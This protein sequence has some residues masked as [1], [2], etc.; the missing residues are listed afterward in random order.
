MEECSNQ[1]TGKL[2]RIIKRSLKESRV[3]QDWKRANIVPNHK[4]GDKE[5]PLNY[6]PVSLRSEVAKICEKIMKDR[7]L[8]F[9]VETNTLSGGQFGFREGSSCITNLLSFYSSDWCYKGKRRMGWLHLHGHQQCFWQGTSQETLKTRKCRI[10]G[11]FAE[12]DGRLFEQQR[13][14]NSNKR[15]EVRMMQCEK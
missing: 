15:P 14:E 4:G 2:H 11:W 12:M 1:L 9:L 5:E 10:E 6:R 3:F 13:N 7:W 8:K